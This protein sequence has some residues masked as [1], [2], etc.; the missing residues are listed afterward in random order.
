[1]SNFKNGRPWMRNEFPGKE[2]LPMKI[3][4]DVKAGVGSAIYLPA[5]QSTH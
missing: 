5:M 3:K 4:T 2:V 1:M